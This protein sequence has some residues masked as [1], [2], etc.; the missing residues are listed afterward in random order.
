MISA[1]ENIAR[2]PHQARSAA[3]DFQVCIHRGTQQIGGTCIE[4]ACQGKRILLDLGLP[5][6]AGD[7]D[8]ISLVPA[9]PGLNTPD[10][11][12]LA[13][14]L[15]HGHSDHWGLV[16]H[17]STALP[18]VTGAA[19]RRILDAASAFVP[20]AISI[21]GGTEDVPDLVDRKTIHLGP[22][23]IT[24]FLVD[25]SAYDAYALLIEA[26]GRRLFYSGDIRAHGRKAALFERL[27]SQPP[28]PVHAMLMEGSSLGRLNPGQQF[29]TESAIEAQMVE[30]FGPDGFVGVCASAQNIDRVVSIYRACKR[31]G[32]TL[33]LDL[34]A[35]EILRATGN[36]SVPA[37]GW[38]N[39]AVYV[40]EYQRRHIARTERF[41]IVARYKPNRIYREAIST[42]VARSV[43]LFRPAMVADI[44]LIPQAW[45]GAR[46]IWSQWDGYLTSPPNEAFLAKLTS[47]K[48]PL[49]VV[50]TS[51]HASITDL[52]R[53]ATAIAPEALIPV[54]TFGG[55]RFAE[56]FGSHVDRREDGE[57]WGV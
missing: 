53:L 11:S 55:D 20:G 16:P 43:M 44:D 27:L 49:E 37:A 46:M 12:L 31:T 39:L 2:Q 23:A 38:S 52:Q 34:Y 33:L 42:L 48:V 51:G 57:W 8:P 56:L 3:D 28:R 10:A 54:H 4:L 14:V 22:F 9:V 30:R 36:P 6:D 35:M 25:H 17:V 41:D 13:L 47:R 5:L 21:A 29:P 32:R 50:H 7:T 19:T 18:I 40:P 24:P 1:E 45:T 15:S 26:D